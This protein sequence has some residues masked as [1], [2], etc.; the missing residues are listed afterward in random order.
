[1]NKYYTILILLI[2]SSQ[3]IT[4]EIRGRVVDE[5][6]VPL[7]YVSVYLENTTLGT[8]SNADG[9]YSIKAQEQN[10]RVVFQY[11][12]YQ[13]FKKSVVDIDDNVLNVELKL[14]T[15]WL[16]EVVIS[17]NREDPAYEIMRKAI[18]K[19]SY[20]KDLLQTYDC[21]VYVKGNQK[22]I[23]APDEIFGEHID[24]IEGIVLDSTRSGIVY[25]SETLSHLSVDEGNYKEKVVSSK[26][27]G[28]DN[29]YSFNSAKEMSFNFYNNTIEIDREMISPIA[30]N[31]M[32]YYYYELVGTFTES[33]GAIINHIKVIPKRT[34][35]PSFYGAIY[36]VEDTWNIHSLK[37]G[38]TP[39][40]ARV[41]VLD[42]LMFHQIFLPVTTDGT[43]ALF[44]NTINFKASILD[45]N[46]KGVFTAVYSNYSFVTK[47]END[48]YNEFVHIVDVGS[49]DRSS[50]HWD[51]IR[52]VPLTLEE[53]RD[54]RVKDSIEE[55]ITAPSYMDSVD[56]EFSKFQL[57]DLALEYEYKKR[58]KHL[59]YTVKSPISPG[60][61]NTVQ[62]YRMCL[63]ID[64]VKYFD[65]DETRRLLFGTYADFG[66]AEQE[67]RLK[68]YLKFR[69]S[70]IHRH[71]LTLSGGTSIE[72]FNR[73]MP[74][75]EFMNTA[76]ML[77]FRENHAKYFGRR[78][79]QLSYKLEPK[80][81]WF[82]KAGVRWEDRLPLI[83]HSDDS[84]FKVNGKR[85]I[86]NDPQSP[87]SFTP[88]FNRHQAF[89]IDLSASFRF[90]QKFQLRPDRKVLVD[91]GGPELSVSYTA[92][93]DVGGSDL[94]YQKIAV[95]LEDYWQLGIVGT[96]RYYFN[97]GAFVNKENIE[98]VDYQH[99]NGTQILLMKSTDYLKSFLL[100]PYYG[101]STSNGHIQAH[102]EHHFNGFVF[103]KIPLIQELGW[104]LVVG[105]KTLKS[106][107][108]PLYSEIHVGI[109]NI[110]YDF[111]RLLRVD[112][113]VSFNDG[114]RKWGVRLSVGLFD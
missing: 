12:G 43:W 38:V 97:A 98:F 34:S 64:G 52:P 51:S 78:Q 48:F 113:V 27:S 85:F 63:K 29:G 20:H 16:S 94:S 25:L 6:N 35:D 79:I 57:I 61:F 73:T 89:L 81:G 108:H 45:L 13:T 86:S 71:E 65:E 22:M 106:G 47:K 36:I 9:Y 88:S 100:L 72:Q 95:S 10:S 58:S 91:T 7:A 74:I 110:G 1:M 67:F 42:T 60:S 39:E 93:V 92:A 83:N 55:I 103:D 46:I 54:Y 76:Y 37:L 99:F 5:N 82:F 14:Q 56:R 90:G 59:Y 111:V 49:N 26:V 41:Y 40:A 66:F 3:G 75:T 8:T 32:A 102:V 96:F 70:R 28:D 53:I 15:T 101:H 77:L 105:A 84:I 4:Q 50:S 107:V 69:P 18:A 104:S 109:E 62:G 30:D 17:S 2:Y 21:D 33:N 19:R 11:I 24:D 31:A 68:G 112:G 23:N 80:S 114:V 44:S 87:N